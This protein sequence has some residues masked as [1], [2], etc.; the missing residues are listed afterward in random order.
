MCCQGFCPKVTLLAEKTLGPRW[1]PAVST[2]RSPT[3]LVGLFQVALL[4]LVGVVPTIQRMRAGITTD[5]C[6]LLAGFGILLSEDKQEVVGL[7]KYYLWALEGE[8]PGRPEGAQR[9]HEGLPTFSS[10]LP[11]PRGVLLDMSLPL[12]GSHLPHLQAGVLAVSGSGSLRLEGVIRAAP[13]LVRCL[14]GL[15]SAFG[16]GAGQG[17]GVCEP[18][19]PCRGS[20]GGSD[21]GQGA[22]F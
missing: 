6:Y 4:L 13:G 19:Q 2:A 22:G 21:V 16:C 15:R 17:F 12:S 8:A 9:G 7:V 1:G 20:E 14:P 5:I 10:S 3:F 11:G 18:L